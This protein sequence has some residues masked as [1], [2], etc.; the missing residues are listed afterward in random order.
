MLLAVGILG[1]TVMPHVIWLHS[2]LMQDRI[3]TENEEQKRRLMRFTRIDVTIAM[4]IAGLI[5]VAML[6]MAA[7]TFFKTGH[8]HVESLETRAQDARAAARR[9]GERALRDRAASRP[10][11]RA[12]PS[13]RS[14]ARS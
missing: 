3:R 8:H 10:G 13:A 5:N 7:S 14:R 11:S 2:A 4:V 12:R 6:V 1:A 9:R